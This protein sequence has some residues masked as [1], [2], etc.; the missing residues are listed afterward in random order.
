[1]ASSKK[2]Q[3]RLAIAAYDDV[4]AAVMTL[5]SDTSPGQ[6]IWTV[7]SY[8]SAAVLEKLAA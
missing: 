5:N 1:M 8:V 6:P 7:S 3:I 4:V 2:V